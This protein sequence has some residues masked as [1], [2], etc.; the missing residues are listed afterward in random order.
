M[1]GQRVKLINEHKH[2]G[3]TFPKCCVG[4]I[5]GENEGFVIFSY[6]KDNKPLAVNISKS[7]IMNINKS[8]LDIPYQHL[9]KPEFYIGAK[10]NIQDN[11][12]EIIDIKLAENVDND[13]Y[14]LLINGNKYTIKFVKLNEII[15]YV[16]IGMNTEEKVNDIFEYL[17]LINQD[18]PEQEINI[19][20]YKFIFVGDDIKMP[21]IRTNDINKFIDTLNQIKIIKGV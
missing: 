8:D 10:F 3:I 17:E 18:K 4:T 16:P 15:S 21:T 7:N 1:L 20:G 12:A 5:V 13:L 14:T 2:F 11:E 19:N 6:Y 9:I